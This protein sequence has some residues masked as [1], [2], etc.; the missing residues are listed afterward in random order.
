MTFQINVARCYDVAKNVVIDFSMQPY[1]HIF[2]AVN[3]ANILY[4]HTYNIKM[5][6][7]QLTNYFIELTWRM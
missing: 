2:R 3:T 6:S 1:A 7:A 5:S 4:K